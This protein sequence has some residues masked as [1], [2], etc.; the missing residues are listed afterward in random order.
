MKIEYKKDCC[1]FCDPQTEG[2]ITWLGYD[3][4]EGCL[5]SS[6]EEGFYLEDGCLEAIADDPFCGTGSLKIN[7]CPI[8]GRSLK[9]VYKLNEMK[10]D[11]Q[12]ENEDET[13]R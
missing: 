13:N 8:C 3:N 7:F 12:K 6:K 5:R 11:F 4:I 10:N 1:S 9:V 2:K